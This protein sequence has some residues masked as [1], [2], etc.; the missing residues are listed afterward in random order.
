MKRIIALV[1]CAM[2]VAAVVDAEN[3]SRKSTN[4]TYDQLYQATLTQLNED[5]G[6]AA[7]PGDRAPAAVE[8]V[9]TPILPDLLM[10]PVYTADRFAVP[11][12]DS[13]FSDVSEP[14]PG[15]GFSENWQ[16]PW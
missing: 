1:L 10:P 15:S 3:G 4:V 5:M 6:L 2:S 14:L 11:A 9:I 16:A 7:A 13:P 8:T 12:L